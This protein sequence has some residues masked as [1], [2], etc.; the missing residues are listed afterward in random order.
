[1]TKRSALGLG[2]AGLLAMASAF[3]ALAQE[4]KRC[5]GGK[6]LYQGRC[7]YPDEIARAKADAEKKRQADEARHKA[8]K[9][10]RLAQE[11]AAKDDAACAAAHR[12]DTLASWKQYLSDFPDGR[13]KPE[14][15]GR[16]A[17]LEPP[18]K[19]VEPPPP[20]TMPDSAPPPV[21]DKS[22]GW[23]GQSPLVWIGFG[24]GAA[25]FLTWGIAGGVAI[26]KRSTLN[27][28]CPDKVCPSSAQGDLDSAMA[29]AHASTVGMVI[30]FAGSAVGIVGL[31]LPLFGVGDAKAESPAPE[32]S[33]SEAPVSAHWVVGPGDLRLVG[34]F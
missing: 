6:E 31:L 32:A 10:K 24:V 18:A 9:E 26:G 1:M 5:K 11:R 22:T 4:P 27:D 12:T 21:E 3:P 20:P 19:P 25:G 28:E 30:G 7:L 29:A 33:P 14:A 34:K 15:D 13:C 17:A 23:L 2:V 8:E 16:V